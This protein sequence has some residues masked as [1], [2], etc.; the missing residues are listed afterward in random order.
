MRRGPENARGEGSSGPGSHALHVT[1]LYAA[2]PP[3]RQAK[4]F[5]PAPE[6]TRKVAAH[7]PHA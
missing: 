2:L 1:A 3:E 7:D 5:G 4:V 6:G